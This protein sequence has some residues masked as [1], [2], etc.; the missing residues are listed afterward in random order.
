MAVVMVASAAEIEANAR[1]SVVVIVAVSPTV[2]IATP[3]ASVTVAVAPPVHFRRRR[4]GCCRGSQHAE[5]GWRRAC[6]ARHEAGKAHHRSDRENSPPRHWNLL[7]RVSDVSSDPSSQ[8]AIAR[9][10][11]E[12]DRAPRACDGV[13]PEGANSRRRFSSLELSCYVRRKGR[14]VVSRMASAFDQVCSWPQ[15]GQRIGVAG[16]SGRLLK[17]SLSVSIPTGTSCFVVGQRIKI[18]PI[19]SST[20]PARR[21]EPKP[22]SIYWL[23]E[24]AVVRSCVLADG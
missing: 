5:A 10:V 12:Q 6:G 11:P 16:M 15:S 2:T 20:S 9:S 4:V 24:F 17:L 21:G 18:A 3:V 13:A 14:P 7:L 8:L 22:A 1:P 23:R 19:A